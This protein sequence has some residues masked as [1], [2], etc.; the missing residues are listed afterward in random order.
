MD[1]KQAELEL[2][3]I[4][5]IMEDSRR[6]MVD[7]GTGFIL[8]G[9]LVALGLISSYLSVLGYIEWNITSI[10]WFALIGL[11]WLITIFQLRREKKVRK[12][13]SF[14]EKVAGA[15]WGSAGITMT[16]IGFVGSYTGL[17]KGMGISPLMACVLAA[18]FFVSGVIYNDKTFRYL[19]FGWWAGALVMFF[20]HSP[21]TLLLFAIMIILMQVLPGYVMY[22]KWKKEINAA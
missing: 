19:S 13:V 7:D 21:H 20:W 9:F 16:I 18:A 1:T 10:A 6:I 14:A 4:K 8:W 11:G 22:N 5:R 15:I 12:S 3:E 2:S 17:V